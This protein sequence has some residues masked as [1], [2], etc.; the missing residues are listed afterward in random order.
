MSLESARLLM[1]ND[2]IQEILVRYSRSGSCGFLRTQLG[3]ESE[4]YLSFGFEIV[5]VFVAFANRR[6]RSMDNH[7]IKKSIK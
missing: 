4:R 1:K 6:P 2:E 3:R 7:I 5:L